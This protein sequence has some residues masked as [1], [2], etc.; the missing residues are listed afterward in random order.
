MSLIAFDLLPFK[1]RCVYLVNLKLYLCFLTTFVQNYF[2]KLKKKF[3][4]KH[5]HWL[6]IGDMIVI[7]LCWFAHYSGTFGP[8]NKNL[9]MVKC[10]EMLGKRQNLMRHLVALHSQICNSFI[11]KNRLQI[12]NGV[13]LINQPSRPDINTQFSRLLT[14]IWTLALIR[15]E[16]LKWS[17]DNLL[18]SYM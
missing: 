12:F 8:L 3:S 10:S 13:V 18:I 17:Y 6:M 16:T 15:G 1:E 11:S 5:H 9:K 14:D 2:P 7:N 4:A